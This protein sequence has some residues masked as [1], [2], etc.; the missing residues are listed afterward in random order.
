[1]SR[2]LRLNPLTN[3]LHFRNSNDKPVRNPIR[4]TEK[5]VEAWKAARN[6]RSTLTLKDDGFGELLYCGDPFEIVEATRIKP[7]VTYAWICDYQTRHKMTEACDCYERLNVTAWRFKQ[8]R[9]EAA[10]AKPDPLLRQ[11]GKA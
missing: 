10:E 4:V 9:K 7:P 11:H 6:T 5:Q 3:Y 8:L 1:M 2:G